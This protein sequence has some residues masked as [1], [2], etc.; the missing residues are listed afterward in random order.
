MRKGRPLSEDDIEAMRKVSVPSGTSV[1]QKDLFT[2]F[3]KPTRQRSFTAFRLHI[4]RYPLAFAAAYFTFH[5]SSMTVE[6]MYNDPDLWKKE[7]DR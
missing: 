4:S 1:V 2:S 5:G 6:H 3:Q 7:I